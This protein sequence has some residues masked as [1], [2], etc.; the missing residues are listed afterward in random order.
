MRVHFTIHSTFIC[1]N[2]SWYKVKIRTGGLWGRGEGAERFLPP[3]SHT[4]PQSRGGRQ[5]GHP[6]R[7]PDLSTF[8]NNQLHKSGMI[9]LE[10]SKGLINPF[11]YSSGACHHLTDGMAIL[12]YAVLTLPSTTKV[13]FRIRLHQEGASQ[14]AQMVKNLPAMQETLVWSLSW[15]RSPGERNGYLF[16]CS[17]LENSMD[18]GSWQA[19]VYGVAKSQTWLRD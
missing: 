13:L 12:M 2:L 1:W 15:G 9:A 16:Q 8:P 6:G 19:I 17:C 7:G 14:M 11:Q 18:R 10:S 5:Q 4:S 3:G